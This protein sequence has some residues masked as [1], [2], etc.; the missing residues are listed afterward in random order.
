MNS[1]IT[2]KKTEG[3]FNRRNGHLIYD[4]FVIAMLAL[5]CFLCLYPSRGIEQ[6]LCR[7]SHKG[8]LPYD[9]I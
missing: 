7:M 9:C 3:F 8:I 2:R 5:I 1:S 6:V 4:I